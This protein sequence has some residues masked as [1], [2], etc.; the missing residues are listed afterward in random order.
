[1][2]LKLLKLGKRLN[3]VAFT[4]GEF[5]S[6]FRADCIP[7]NFAYISGICLHRRH[8]TI[9]KS[10]QCCVLMSNGRGVGC[11]QSLPVDCRW[12]QSAC[13]LHATGSIECIFIQLST[14][15]C[16]RVIIL[17]AIAHIGV[18]LHN[19]L[20]SAIVMLSLSCCRQ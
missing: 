20:S 13:T 15:I 17:N 5:I 11:V 6:G 16:K 14:V 1:M 3:R 10:E 12:P 8:I 7:F 9:W 2:T 19:K 18:P 4:R